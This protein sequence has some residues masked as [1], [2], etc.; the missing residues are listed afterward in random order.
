MPLRS[1]SRP[2]LSSRARP[3]GR[4][5]RGPSGRKRPR[6]TPQGMTVSRARDAPRRTSS[7]TSSVHVAMTWSARCG[8]LALDLQSLR[9]AGVLL[10]LVAA[11][12]LPSA[13]N[14]CTSGDAERPRGG[15]RGAP[16][17][18]EVRVDDVGLVV[19]PLPPAARVRTPA[20]ARAGRPSGSTAAAPRRRGGRARRGRAR[21][22]R[23]GRRRRGACGRRPR[24]RA[25]AIACASAATCTFCPPASAPP[26][27]AS[28]LACSDTIE[29]LID[30][31]SCSSASQSSRNLRSP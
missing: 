28:G 27:T 30:V 22:T 23:G 21:R 15:H 20:C 26:S 29:I 12:D 25:R 5:S 6:S 9:R 1:T 2:M 13:W 11:L 17:H 16:R 3:G 4:A 31:T 10:A 14:V 24:P 19:A 7:N 8:E 18:P